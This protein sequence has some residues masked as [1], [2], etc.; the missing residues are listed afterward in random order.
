MLPDDESKSVV[1]RAPL[2]SV[3]IPSY[4]HAKYIRKAVDSIL[5]QGFADFELLISDD[6]STDNSWDV[7]SGINDSRIRSFKQEKN[8]GPVGNLVF[9]IEQ[10]R[11]KYIALLN[12]DDTWYPT[13]LDKQVAILE[14]QPELGACF[15]WADLVDE[16]GRETTG[17]E[18]IWN[19]VF[20]QPNRS[21]GEWLRHFF[22]K[23]NCICHPSMLVRKEVYLELGFYNPGLKQLP[24]FDMWI[25]LVKNFPIHVIQENLVGH[26]RD[27]N[28]TSVV[29]PENSARNLTELVEIFGSFF[30]NL[31]DEVFVEGFGN[32]FRLKGV[33]ATPARLKCE[34]LFLLLDS[35]FAH[36]SGRAAAISSCIKNFSDPEFERVLR[37]EYMFNVFEFY[38]L[39]G[40]SGLGHY[41]MVAHNSQS[42]AISSSQTGSRVPAM[43][44][45]IARYLKGLARRLLRA[46]RLR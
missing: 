17:P 43:G 28:N 16:Q 38:R 6:M 5:Q 18:A 8:L 23:G 35:A 46:L 25:R 3:V 34:K 32:D 41:L 27:G 40:Q 12:S 44:C 13:K 39:T 24:D 1:G 36:A 15:T 2:V 42:M 7:I 14:A 4:N 9:L 19:D 30:E 29:S 22:F 26:L 10:A 45:R 31:S 37:D 20:R 11:G 33:P 21:Q